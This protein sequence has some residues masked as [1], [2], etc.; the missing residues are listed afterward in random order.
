MARPALVRREPGVRLVWHYTSWA[1]LPRIVAAGRLLPGDA[2]DP[3]ETPMLWF[4]ARQD[5][6]PTATAQ[7]VDGAQPRMLTL[8]E[9]RQRFGCV[10]F[11]LPGG[12]PRLSP[13]ELACRAAGMGLTRRRKLEAWSR[14]AGANPADWFGTSQAIPLMGLRFQVLLDEWGEGDMSAMARL[15]TEKRG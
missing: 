12:D 4:S 2:Q 7:V 9:H 10:R 14:Q 5:W 15:W 8:Q 13:W 11:G 6:E 1:T 3:G